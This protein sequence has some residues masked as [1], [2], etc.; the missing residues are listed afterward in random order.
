MPKASQKGLAKAPAESPPSASARES[1]SNVRVFSYYR[2]IFE[3]FKLDEAGHVSLAELL[4]RVQKSGIGPEDPRVA[5]S[6]SWLSVDVA[7]K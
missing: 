6:T 2:K 7:G 4:H 1:T 5:Q 3:S